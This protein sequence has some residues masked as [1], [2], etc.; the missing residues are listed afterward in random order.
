VYEPD[1]DLVLLMNGIV[2]FGDAYQNDVK[3]LDCAGGRWLQAGGMRFRD[4]VPIET[5]LRP[6]RHRRPAGGGGNQG[7]GLQQWLGDASG[8]NPLIDVTMDGSKTIFAQ[9]HTGSVGVERLP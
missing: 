4:G 2:T 6:G 9:F 8:S 1:L 3:R 7:Y 5:L